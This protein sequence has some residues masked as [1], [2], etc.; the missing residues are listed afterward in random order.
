MDGS[1]PPQARVP[2]LATK[3]R[4][5]PLRANLVARPHL[6]QRLSAYLDHQMTLISAPAGFGKST[7]VGD[8]VQTL[9]RPVA[10]LSLDEADSAPTRFLRYLSA[11]LQQID[12]ALGRDLPSLLDVAQPPPLD[13]V[14]SA[15]INDLALCP[16]DFVLVLDDFHSLDN[17]AIHEM[18][19]A[20]LSHQLNR[21]HLVIITR[22]D[23]PLP[24][25]RLRASGQLGELRALDLRFSPDE[26]QRF[27]ADVMGLTL[28]P[29]NLAALDARIEGWIA[30]LQL[31]ALS[32]HHYQDPTELIQTLSGNH[33]FILTYL[34]EEVLRQLPPDR[35]SFLLETSVLSRLSGPLCDAVTER[36]ES[37]AVLAALYTSN[38]FV[39]ALDEEHRWYRYHRLFADLL[40]SR[41]EATRPGYAAELHKRASLWYESHDM[42]TDAIEHAFAAK[43]YARVTQLLERYARPLILDGYAQTVHEWLQRLPDEWRIAGPRAN[44]AFAWSLLLGGRLSEIE[45]YLSGAEAAVRRESTA[46]TITS[47]LHA[48]ILALRS[49]LISLRGETRRACDMAAQAVA[50]AATGDLYAQG[51][52][53]FCLATAT[54]YDGRLVQAIEAYQQALPLCREAGNKLAS[55]LIVANLGMLYIV[56]GRLR[57]ADDLSRQVMETAERSGDARTPALTTVYGI[58]CEVCYERGDLETAAADLQLWLDLSKRSGHVAAMAYGHVIAARIAQAQGDLAAAQKMLDEAVMMRQFR[59]PA[60]VATH[61]AGQQ[62]SLAL[63]EDDPDAA[64]QVLT[65]TG[66][67]ADDEPHHQREI[68]QIA[69]LRLM[70]YWGRHNASA[71]GWKSANSLAA[72]L[73][74]DAEEGGRMGRVL[75][76]LLLRCLLLQ[77]QG[78]EEAALA[79][80][81]RAITLATPEGYVQRFVNAGAPMALLLYR[82]RGRGGDITGI[83]RLLARFPAATAS[84]QQESLIE[85]LSDRELDVLRLMADGLTYQQVADRLVVSLNTVRFHVKGIY[86]KLGVDKRIAAVDRARA[87]NLLR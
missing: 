48:E 32:L 50:K 38:A 17:S 73:L 53:R 84:A 35:Q 68:I 76:V 59:M 58:H 21:M 13:L 66:V 25:A 49:A 37:S 33:H 47:G 41:L 60:W 57:A 65:A 85:P 3:L 1:T 30:G 40:R 64:A 22:E 14:I 2:L 16:L 78:K 71:D 86:G 74:A 55:M 67:N 23:P 44:L 69:Y 20:L 45:T 51:I 15:L 83:D 9:D 56:Q 31:A 12:A 75:D 11:A 39:L 34:T 77:A 82:L 36:A 42:A 61:V 63:A 10:W 18:V 6:L 8:W 46:E 72:R 26:A 54:N 70:L 52:T 87:L 79:D 24:L 7:L 62:A 28:A 19:S 27:L 5:P 4:V 29:H 81:N 43:A 80:L